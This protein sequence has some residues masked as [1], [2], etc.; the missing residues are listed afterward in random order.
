VSRRAWA[1][2]AA[3]SLLWGVP[4]LLIRVADRAFTPADVVFLRTAVG[5]ALLLPF[6]ARRGHLLPLLRRWRL[7]LGYIV[8]EI[9]VPWFLLSDAERRLPSSLSGLLVAA[10]PLVGVVVSRLGPGREPVDLRRVAGLVVGLVGVAVLLGFQVTGADVRSVLEVAVVV[11]GYAVGP[12]I[13]AR[14]LA[15]LPA[16]PLMGTAL[17]VTALGYAP[18]GILQLPAHWP[19]GWPV[20]SVIGLGVFCTAAAFVLFFELILEVG[21][22]RA[23]LVTYVNPVV[24]VALGV[25]VLSEPVTPGT[26]IGLLLILGG[27]AVA[28][29]PTRRRPVTVAGRAADRAVPARVA[30]PAASLADRTSAQRTDPAGDRWRRRAMRRSERRARRFPYRWSRK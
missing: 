7:L 11:V 3:M 18:V 26:G 4:Y 25:G 27:C 28:T 19:G 17:G 5:A 9:A 15:D 10:V 29:R 8:V 23:T 14:G 13:L 21:P 12:V 22:V 6:A 24:A 16:V 1:L 30:T 2:F 20:L